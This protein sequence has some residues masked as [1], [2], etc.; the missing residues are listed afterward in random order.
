MIRW[1]MSFIRP[2]NQADLGQTP[3]PTMSYLKEKK[4]HARKMKRQ[5]KGKITR[6]SSNRRLTSVEGRLPSAVRIQ[7]A[8]VDRGRN[9]QKTDSR[10]NRKIEIKKK[11][12]SFQQ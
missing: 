12:K 10:F 11:K 8:N 9:S 4:T 5:G 2:G 6:R 7:R 3:S 1:E